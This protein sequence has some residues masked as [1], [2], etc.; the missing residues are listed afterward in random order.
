MEP[1]TALGPPPE[2]ASARTPALLQ[3]LGPGLLPLLCPL[4]SPFLFLFVQPFLCL[5]AFVSEFPPS[6]GRAHIRCSINV[7]WIRAARCCGVRTLSQIQPGPA[8][9]RGGAGALLLVQP[10]PCNAVACLSSEG[11]VG[12]GSPAW[13]F[14][15]QFPC[16]AGNIG[17]ITTESPPTSLARCDGG[18]AST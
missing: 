5:P 6:I 12:R 18:G 4:V 1:A 15:D 8:G 10:S 3:A 13:S 17:S 14:T 16:L 2:P 11:G 9:I 7:C